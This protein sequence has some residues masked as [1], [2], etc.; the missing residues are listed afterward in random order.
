MRSLGFIFKVVGVI[1]GFKCGGLELCFKKNNIL[2]M[3]EM[4]WKIERVEREKIERGLSLF[5]RLKK[6]GRRVLEWKDVRG[7]GWVEVL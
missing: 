5:F 1:E 4:E 6:G 3:C 2:I 7:V